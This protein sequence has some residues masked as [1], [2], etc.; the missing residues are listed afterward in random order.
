MEK[1]T[2]AEFGANGRSATA[3]TFDPTVGM[4]QAFMFGATNM[5][6]ETAGFGFFMACKGVDAA[7]ALMTCRTP[8][9]FIRTQTK[10]A[11]EFAA[12]WTDEGTRLMSVCFDTL[13]GN[14]GEGGIENLEADEMDLPKAA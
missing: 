2:T 14:P 13:A 6:E 1:N 12:A 9:E 7:A 5:I 4:P 8:D 10:L 11:G 3:R